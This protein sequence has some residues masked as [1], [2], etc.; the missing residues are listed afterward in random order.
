MSKQRSVAARAALAFAL[1]VVITAGGAI[2][3]AAA[4]AG[5]SGVLF[6]AVVAVR[7]TE[8]YSQAIARQDAAYGTPVPMPISR[9]FYGGA[10]EPWPG[11]AGLSGRPVIVSFRYAPADVVA[12]RH[13]A[14]VRQFFAGAPSYDVYWSYSHEP[15]DNIERGEFTAPAYRA[16]W[17]RIADLAL[18]AAPTSARLHST[19]IVMC[20]T[21]NPASGR[22]WRD[23]YV[24]AAQSMLAFDCYNH[25]SKRN[26][27]ADPADFLRPLTNW[28][29]ANPTIPWGVSEFGSVRVSSD[30]DGSKRA[31]WLRSV[32]RFLVNQHAAKPIAAIFG[33]YF[34]VLGPKGT[35][36]R[37]TDTNSR[38][39]WRDV[40]QNY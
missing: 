13:D 9:V 29:A 40:V 19:L 1:S 39:A 21:M 26:A 28:A 20:Y 37:L 11:L 34:D 38:L 14:A 8:S 4:S 25:A 15:E 16:A 36:Y 3:S 23:Y 7:G 32:G 30:P 5:A 31:A 2:T 22:N 27:Y 17:Q 24:P 10:P 12:G 35:D 33:N 6:G 18:Q